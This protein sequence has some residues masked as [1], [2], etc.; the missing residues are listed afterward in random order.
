MG[1]K[2]IYRW[3]KILFIPAVISGIWLAGCSAKS[4]AQMEREKR[5][6]VSPQYKDGKFNNPFFAPVMAPGSTWKYIKK[7]L[8]ETRTDPKPEGDLPVIPVRQKEWT[9][10]DKKS[11]SF[12]WLGHSS[13][14]IALESKIILVDPVL[15][16]RASPLTW[17]GPKRF[18]PAPV[19]AG[20]LPPVDVVVITHDHY[21]HLE[22]PT[23]KAMARKTQLFLVPLGIGE[24]LEKW[25]IASEKIVE[26][27]WWETHQADNLKFT[28][29][30]AIHYAKRG[31]F[32]GDERLWCSWAVN[33]RS[34]SVFV[35]GDSGYFD[36]FK[37]V[38]EKLG[39]FDMTFLKIGAYDEMWK[40]IHMLP[41]E[42]V[43]QHRD[44]GGKVLMPLHWAT[45]DLA[46]HP[47]TE[48]IERALTAARQNKVHIITPSIG[49]R[50]RFSELPG[51]NFWWRKID[52]HKD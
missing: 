36:G 39:P 48:P 2:K 31:L 10:N 32:D 52:K 38:G 19:S 8:F 27:D 17:V 6:H 16:E 23:M 15:E 33:G 20:A 14:L 50:V 9:N 24:L 29:T 40:Q 46:L 13:I 37:K 4:P 28:A 18:H 5:V 7:T 49:E 11:L 45:F 35:S 44:L 42:A 12:A 34:K 47:W 51:E 30:P 25:G 26:L 43:Q 41:E 22:A 1:F 21:D 3:I